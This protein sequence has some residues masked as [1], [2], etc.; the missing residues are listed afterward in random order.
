ML[1]FRYLSQINSHTVFH[2]LCCHCDKMEQGGVTVYTVWRESRMDFLCESD[3][4]PEACCFLPQGPAQRGSIHMG[5]LKAVV[6]R[7]KFRKNQYLWVLSRCFIHQTPYCLL[8]SCYQKP[9]YC[10]QDQC[11]KFEDKVRWLIKG[12]VMLHKNI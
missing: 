1:F 10:L 7:A 5:P 9:T 12:R 4:V 11:G 8:S 6:Q 2:R 3:S